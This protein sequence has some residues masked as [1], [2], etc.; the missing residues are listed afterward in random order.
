MENQTMDQGQIEVTQQ[1]VREQINELEQRIK[2]DVATAIAE[3]QA[4]T[5]RWVVTLFIGS[6]GLMAMIVSAFASS[7][8]LR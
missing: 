1:F 3:A 8:F 5:V 6:V 2:L 4:S 7:L